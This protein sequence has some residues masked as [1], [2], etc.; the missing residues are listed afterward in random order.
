MGGAWSSLDN[1]YV[2]ESRKIDDY[3]NFDLHLKDNK[4]D[5]EKLFKGHFKFHNEQHNDFI[6]VGK[7]YSFLA[8][9]ID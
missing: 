3:T 5:R 7:N 2:N 8:Q 4:S 9:Q 1:N 6:S